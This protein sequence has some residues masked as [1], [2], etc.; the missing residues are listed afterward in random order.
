MREGKEA[1]RLGAKTSGIG[2]G[3]GIERAADKRVVVDLLMK[4][5]LALELALA[6]RAVFGR[7]SARTDR[8]DGFGRGLPSS[9]FRQEAIVS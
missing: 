1:F 6:F 3:R 4:R 8:V 2:A 9:P 7:T 5:V